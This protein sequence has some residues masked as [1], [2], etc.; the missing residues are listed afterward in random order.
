MNPEKITELTEALRAAVVAVHDAEANL[1]IDQSQL[2]LHE[3]RLS[4][5]VLTAV[6]DDGKALHTNDTARKAAI[7]FAAANDATVLTALGRVQADRSELAEASAVLEAKRAEI[8]LW[9]A[10]LNSRAEVER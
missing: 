1:A 7:Q 4:L 9:C 2:D 10:M 5:Q 6:G 3:A 8:K